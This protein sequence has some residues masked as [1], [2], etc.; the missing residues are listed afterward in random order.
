MRAALILASAQ[1]AAGC[2]FARTGEQIRSGQHLLG[3]FAPECPMIGFNDTAVLIPNL[4]VGNWTIV[5]VGASLAASTGRDMCYWSMQLLPSPP[6]GLLS[7]GTCSPSP[8]NWA[9]EPAL[10]DVQNVGRLGDQ[11]IQRLRSLVGAGVVE[12]AFCGAGRTNAA[13]SCAANASS[14]YCSPAFLNMSA[15]WATA[16]AVFRMTASNAA[17]VKETVALWRL[18]PTEHEP[19]ITSPQVQAGWGFGG[20]ITFKFVP[21][22]IIPAR[23]LGGAGA[24]TCHALTSTSTPARALF[25]DAYAFWYAACNAWYDPVYSPH[26]GGCPPPQQQ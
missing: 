7:N 25:D 20:G 4:E 11:A 22:D 17:A 12:N 24:P 15:M 13:V 23:F 3:E 5:D 9:G 18:L 26:G 19:A 21:C 2:A 1:I 14:P 10:S 8:C 16:S 6:T